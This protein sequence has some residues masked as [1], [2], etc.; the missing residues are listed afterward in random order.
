MRHMDFGHAYTLSRLMHS[1]DMI[2]PF[3][4]FNRLS[5]KQFTHKKNHFL[6]FE[7]SNHSNGIH[8]AHSTFSIFNCRCDQQEEEFKH[9][10]DGNEEDEMRRNHFFAK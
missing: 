6:T 10:T 9:I 2:A 8:S 5:M 3:A 1:D 7:R 4:L